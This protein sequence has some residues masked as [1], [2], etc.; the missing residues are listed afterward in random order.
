[1]FEI[2]DSEAFDFDIIIFLF[3]SIL[4]DIY[5]VQLSNQAQ[6]CVHIKP[7]DFGCSLLS[8]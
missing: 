1:M 5:F 6:N 7:L 4:F 2:S 8:I 3:H